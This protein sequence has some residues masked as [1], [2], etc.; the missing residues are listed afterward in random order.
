[1]AGC[2]GGAIPR[3]DAALAAQA[4]VPVAQ[5]DEGRR[6]YVTS[7]TGCHALYPT[8]TFDQQ[9]WQAVMHKMAPKAKLSPEASALVLS[10]LRATSPT[11]VG[12]REP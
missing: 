4:G 2:A 8:A 9:E 12:R 1:M 11:R 6:L 5:L 7:C 3:P 10:Y